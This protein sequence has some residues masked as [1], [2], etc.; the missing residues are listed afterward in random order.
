MTRVSGKARLRVCISV[1]A[2]SPSSW[3]VASSRNRI[4]GLCSSA[5]AR[6]RRCCSP[7]ERM[8]CHSYGLSKL[9]FRRS[10]PTCSK[11]V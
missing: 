5:R 3:L 7:P 6:L 10:S 1:N 9:F 2:D 4:C 8:P 11:V